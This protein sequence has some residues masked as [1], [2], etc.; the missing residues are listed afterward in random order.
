MDRREEKRR[1]ARELAKLNKK[2]HIE[3]F[4]SHTIALS[5]GCIEWLASRDK[6]RYGRFRIN[7][8]TIFAHRWIFEQIKGPL[9]GLQ[10][11]HTCDNPSCVNPD[12]LFAGTHQDNMQD[13]K[14]KGRHHNTKKTHCKRGH[15]LPNLI[16]NE[17]RGACKFCKELREI[18][19]QNG[20]NIG[21]IKIE[22][23][24]IINVKIEK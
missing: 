23:R 7:G 8:N 14:E 11:C 15:K 2:T 21:Y 18:G 3:R 19:Y 20:R 5:S 13:K 1:I 16:P 9:N 22:N 12:H 17:A 6:R 10:C 24:I 4:M